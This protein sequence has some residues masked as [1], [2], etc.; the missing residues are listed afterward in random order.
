MSDPVR[1][2]LIA[3][4]GLAGLSAAIAL[5]LRGWHVRVFDQAPALEEVGAGLQIS[6]NG[7]KLLDRLGVTETLATTRVDHTAIELR[8]GATGRRIFR[9]PMGAAAKA[10]WGARPFMVH[11]ADLQRAL[12]QRLKGLQPDAVTLGARATEYATDG[13]TARLK[14]GAEWHPGALVI[15]A[16]G[17]HSALRTQMHGP[18]APRYTGMMAWRALVSADAVSEPLPSGS[19]AW[20]G[21][22]RHA[23]TTWIRGGELI[24]F[25]GL[26]ERAEAEVEGWSNI[27]DQ[28]QAIKDFSGF[29]P[30]V[31]EVL[32][33]APEVLRWGLY[34]RDPLPFW[35]EGRAILIGDA[36]HPMLP[37][38][39]QGAVQAIE[40]AWVLAER[41][42]H[43]PIM[44]ALAA[45]YAARID[46]VSR[47]QHLS[48]ANA[49][50]FHRRSV[51]GQVATYGPS[52]IAG[53]LLPWGIYRRF[54]WVYGAEFA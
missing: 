31:Q 25:V 44:D 49:G 14:V 9:L 39:A 20:T 29:A 41:L 24:N 32:V 10:R 45:T 51:A 7:V 11:R 35:H 52:W 48:A 30:A 16:D 1:R 2:A 23:V 12:L 21:S 46:R 18:D 33:K 13:S 50:F 38:M 5:A 40:D 42:E 26:V 8:H 19:C 4:A 6:P 53:H 37:S 47:V 54:D 28:A 3:G 17:L 36:A 22:G 43:L 34:T 15:G 27:G